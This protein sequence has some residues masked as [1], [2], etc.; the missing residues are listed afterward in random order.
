MPTRSRAAPTCRRTRGCSTRW[1]P[2][3]RDEPVVVPGAAALYERDAGLLWSHWNADDSVG[4]TRRARQLVL[5]CIATIGNYDYNFNWLFDQDGTLSFA[6]DLTGILNAKA[7][8]ETDASDDPHGVLVA[9]H[10]SAPTHQHFFNL[11]LDLDV[12]GRENQVVELDT[13]GM[14]HGPAN[15]YGNAIVTGETLLATEQMARREASRAAARTWLVRGAG[16]AGGYS[17]VPKGPRRIPYFA[18]QAATARRAA[19][20]E[21]RPLGDSLP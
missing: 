3:T 12:D 1:R 8:A 18:P 21:A 17:L 14:P 6:V 4:Q 20:A 10:V 13:A 16:A 5:T 11:R 7:V 2:T 9:P 15:P 19:F